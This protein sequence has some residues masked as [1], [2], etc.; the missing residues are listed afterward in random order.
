[1]LVGAVGQPGG[2]LPFR[3]A[4]SSRTKTP[5][6]GVLWRCSSLNPLLLKP[7]DGSACD[8][9]VLSHG[10]DDDDAAHTVVGTEKMGGPLTVDIPRN[11]TRHEPILP[12]NN[13]LTSPFVRIP[14]RK[15]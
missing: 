1:M 13:S 7:M 2:R 15:D 10:R 3:F 12:A 6:I 8:S 4:L 14:R 9:L 5:E 11:A